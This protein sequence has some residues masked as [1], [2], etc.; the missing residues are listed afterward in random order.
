MA[1]ENKKNRQVFKKISE[2]SPPIIETKRTSKAEFVPIQPFAQKSPSGSRRTSISSDTYTFSSFKPGS[3]ES[4]AASL[5]NQRSESVDSGISSLSEISNL[6]SSSESLSS[7]RSQG[8]TEDNEAIKNTNGS[9]KE[10][11]E[12]FENK[13]SYSF[14]YENDVDDMLSSLSSDNIDHS[15]R[16]LSS[17]KTFSDTE[18]T[19]I[20]NDKR[21]VNINSGMDSSSETLNLYGSNESLS[22]TVSQGSR[23]IKL[24]K[25]V[26]PPTVPILK[27]KSSDLNNS[28]LTSVIDEN[29]GNILNSEKPVEEEVNSSNPEESLKADRSNGKFTSLKNLMPLQEKVE[30]I[31]RKNQ[32]S[33]EIDEFIPQVNLSAR[34]TVEER[35]KYGT[36]DMLKINVERLNLKI[37]TVSLLESRSFIKVDNNKV[38]K[39]NNNEILLVTKKDISLLKELKCDLDKEL[40]KANKQLSKETEKV[41]IFEQRKQ[42]ELQNKILK[43]NIAKIK[44][45]I[46][47]AKSEQNLEKRSSLLNRL[48]SDL[49]V[50]YSHFSKNL[51]PDLKE[52]ITELLREKWASQT[53]IWAIKPDEITKH[54]LPESRI[55]LTFAEKREIFGR[56]RDAAKSLL[57][58]KQYKG[59]DKKI[60]KKL[61]KLYSNLAKSSEDKSNLENAFKREFGNAYGESYETRS[62]ELGN[63]YGKSCS[64]RLSEVSLSQPTFS[65]GK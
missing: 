7:T 17:F 56:K 2:I 47:T 30:K 24:G 1:T 41:K 34:R 20:E 25:K 54:Y 18:S 42:Q 21:S 14:V 11:F 44:E 57:G 63:A 10:P 43:G 12:S 51:H 16:S 23:S 62:K 6:S 26:A 37:K 27:S 22:S 33:F 9:T 36:F 13:K 5:K 49:K 45:T 53:N 52:A 39:N 32:L 19:S 60:L 29:L 38:D 64:T 55:D 28:N 65:L 35:V 15:S 59:E 3:F 8:I 61:H 40:K 31:S 50:T 48:E 58:S 4:N 46:F